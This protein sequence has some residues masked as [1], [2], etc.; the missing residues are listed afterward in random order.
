MHQTLAHRHRANILAVWKRAETPE[1]S[2]VLFRLVVRLACWKRNRECGVGNDRVRG[3][4]VFDRLGVHER[5][6]RGAWLANRRDRA[7]E[8][9]ARVVASTDER[10]DVPREWI[11]RDGH[12]LQVVG[13]SAFRGRLR[14]MLVT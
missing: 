2:V 7:I 3:N 10:A 12:R 14:E 6:D 11:D 1:L 5:L 4:T 8:R 9:R 13:L